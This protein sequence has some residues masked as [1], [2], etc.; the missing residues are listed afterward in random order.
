MEIQHLTAKEIH[1]KS[2]AEDLF[3]LRMGRALVMI[4][5]ENVTSYKTETKEKSVNE[6]KFITS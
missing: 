2:H 1:L 3:I 5:N 6:N 4:S